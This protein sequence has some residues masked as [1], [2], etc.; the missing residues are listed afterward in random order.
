MTAS[1]I[2]NLTLD[3]ELA[4]DTVN[5]WLDGAVAAAPAFVVATVFFLFGWLVT[6]IIRGIVVGRFKKRDRHDLGLMIGGLIKGAGLVG[7]GLVALSIVVPT[8]RPG[9]LIAGLGIGSVAIGFAFKD[10]LQN[11]LAGFLILLRQPFLVGDTVE[12]NDY[13]G[14]V[15]HIETRSTQLRTFNGQR[16][17][18]PNSEVF[19]NTVLVKTAYEKRRSEY[20]IGIGYG[21][22]LDLAIDTVLKTIGSVE[23]VESDPA[24]Q[25]LTWDLA[26]SWVT[27]RARWWTDSHNTDIVKVY[28]NTIRAIKL[29]FDEAG[30]D[31]PF[32]TQVHLLHDQ[33]EAGD[34][35]RVKQREGWPSHSAADSHT[36]REGNANH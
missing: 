28:A 16:A 22:D 19:S 1:S 20:D 24:P 11:W 35:E 26:P 3:P 2:N 12:I 15:E 25:A 32:E 5:T 31:M 18:I 17:I 30:I 29:A 27:I 4:V 8:I 14:T 13:T 9:D 33:T 23:G 6:S 34:S 7:F 36:N 21:D 10:I